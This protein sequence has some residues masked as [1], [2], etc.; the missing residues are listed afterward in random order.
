MSEPGRGPGQ[1]GWEAIRRLVPRVLFVVAVILLGLALAARLRRLDQ[2]PE[3]LAAL[4]TGVYLLWIA[5]EAP[6]TFGRTPGG[7]A[8][9]KTLMP[10]AV[11]RVG[12]AVSAALGPL[13]WTGYAAWM[14]APVLAFAAGIVLRSSAIR[15][16]GRFYSHFVA[17]DPDHQV[18][19][20]GPYRLVRHPAY[21]GMLLANAGF[22]AFFLNPVSVVLMAA[23]TAAIVW[24]IRVE[25]RV[26]WPVRGYRDYAVGHARLLPGVW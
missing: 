1:S 3:P 11:A 26:L 7:S 8:E 12:T 9:S 6:V 24:R 15:T 18:V 16:L 14:T 17:R 5:A 19:S 25:E 4:L 23:L 10:Y 20:S 22:V 13:H 2:P 21:A